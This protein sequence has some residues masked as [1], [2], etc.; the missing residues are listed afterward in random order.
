MNHTET[1]LTRMEVSH[2][3]KAQ[4]IKR[5]ELLDDIRQIINPDMDDREMREHYE[6]LPLC[7]DN[8]GLYLPATEK[9]KERQIEIHKKKIRAYARKNK[10]LKQY[11]I[12]SEPV[13]GR[14]F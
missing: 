4:A 9:E 3:G 2:R 8:S 13:Q 12:P 11:Q 7:G 14:L 5:P 1:I 10:N 6:P